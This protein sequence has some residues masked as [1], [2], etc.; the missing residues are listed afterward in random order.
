MTFCGD[1]WDKGDMRS[2]PRSERS[3]GP[4]TS[5]GLWLRAGLRGDNED[6]R[7]LARTLNHGQK[8]WNDD[9][10]AVVA[11]A[12]EMAVRRFF[13]TYRHVPVEEF[14]TDMCERIAKERAPSPQ[15]DMEAVIRAALNEN[16]DVPLDIKRGELLRIRGAVTANIT[17][18]L[19]LNADAIDDFVAEAETVAIARGYSPPPAFA[20]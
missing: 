14:V 20:P 3:G 4:R 6:Y 13:A 10:P 12:C 7:R 2:M 18:I 19:K 9:E 16:C 17:D 8:G 15:V 11:A 5:V 1:S